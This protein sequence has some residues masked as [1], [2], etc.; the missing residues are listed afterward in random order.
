M[1][2]IFPTVRTWGAHW[3]KRNKQLMV[4][5]GCFQSSH[6]PGNKGRPGQFPSGSAGFASLLSGLCPFVG[7]EGPNNRTAEA[8]SL[9]DLDMPFQ[10]VCLAR[11]TILILCFHHSL[12]KFYKTTIKQQSEGFLRSVCMQKAK[13]EWDSKHPSLLGLK[14]LF[15]ESMILYQKF[16][17]ILNFTNISIRILYF[18]GL[19]TCFGEN[20]SK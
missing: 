20:N 19:E 13:A 8:C 18:Y 1:D 16:N 15:K 3:D 6:S 7:G 10:G 12:T 4:E 14:A 5:R 17:N 2:F 9:G 11:V